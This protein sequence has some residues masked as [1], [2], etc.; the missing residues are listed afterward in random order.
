[1]P[2]AEK[3]LRFTGKV[4]AVKARISLLRS[5]DQIHH[6][7]EGY[8]LV[9]DGELDWV[10]TKGI[11]VAFGPKVHE[12]HQ[13]IIGDDFGGEVVPV[14][15]PEAEW[16]THYKAS[17]LWF[18]NRGPKEQEVPA[19][20]EGG[21]APPLPEYRKRGHR[22]LDK[23]TFEEHCQRCPFGLVMP[24]QIILDQWNQTETKW[25]FETHCYGPRDCQRYRPGEP[26]R[27]PGR[28]PDMVWVDDDVEREERDGGG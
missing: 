25:R 26:Y 16:A 21:I 27:V 4:T 23:D 3:K 24:T 14:A 18:L 13:F 19:N 10:P 28:K 1:M 7:Y 11:R 6:N 12:K 20:P 17:K 22:R 8:V 15:K 2:T 9:I 5:F